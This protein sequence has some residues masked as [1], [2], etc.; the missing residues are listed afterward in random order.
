LWAETY[1][2]DF[3]DVISLQDE[4]A[5]A[6]ARQIKVALSPAEATR[7]ATVRAVKPE[8]YEFYLKGRYHYYKW[9]PQDF[10]KAIEYFQ[11]AIEIDSDWAP[12]YAGLATSYGWLWIEG[13]VPAQEALPQ[14]NAALKTALAIDDTDPEVRYAL[15]ASAFYYRW[16]WEE[17]DREFQSA[18]ALDPNLVE[19]RFEYAWFLSAMG[20]HSEALTQA[21]KAVDRDPLSVSANLALGSIYFEARQD[22]QAVTQLRRTVELEPSDFRAYVFLTGVYEEKQMYE[23]AI[24]ELQRAM[25]SQGTP[26]EIRASLERTYQQSGSKGYW[27]WRLSEARR[28]NAPYEI[29]VFYARLGNASEAIAWLEKS[30]QQH[31]WHMVQLKMLRVWDPLRSDPRFQDLMRRM[32]FPQ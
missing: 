9:T 22:D 32:N 10:R 18:L 14:F 20:R 25:T 15:A 21:Q 29:A 30:Y 6:V 31:D 4:V 19:A 23:E 13:G 16:D 7:L 11:K 8:A 17:A 28:R 1:E 2:R 27:E 26:P 24:R 3:R 12:A 5:Q